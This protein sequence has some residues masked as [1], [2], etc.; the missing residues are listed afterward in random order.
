VVVEITPA[1]A[2]DHREDPHVLIVHD[3]SNP[4]TWTGMRAVIAGGITSEK[5]SSGT[6]R[7][8]SVRSALRA[9]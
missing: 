5:S 8:P 3:G 9:G 6:R 4:G 7:N 1:V 2:G